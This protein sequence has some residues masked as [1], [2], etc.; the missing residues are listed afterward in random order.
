MW[1]CL[2]RL[3]AEVSERCK[4]ADVIV[5]LNKCVGF[6]NGLA[7]SEAFV[8]WVVVLVL[9]ILLSLVQLCGCHEWRLFKRL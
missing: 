9:R 8:E 4:C 3:H 7:Q 5:V 2:V 6:G 1:L